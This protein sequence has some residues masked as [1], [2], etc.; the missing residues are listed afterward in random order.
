VVRDGKVVGMLV[1]GVWRKT[2]NSAWKRPGFKR[3]IANFKKFN[4]RDL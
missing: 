4:R 2:R 3:D 1:L